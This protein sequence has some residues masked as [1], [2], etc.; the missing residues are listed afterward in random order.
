MHLSENSLQSVTVYKQLGMCHWLT[1]KSISNQI[2]NQMKI[3]N[4]WTAMIKM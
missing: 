1:D 4:E 2:F 3:F